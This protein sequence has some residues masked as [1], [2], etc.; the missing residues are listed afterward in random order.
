MN[1]TNFDAVE[2]TTAFLLEKTG[3]CLGLWRGRMSKADQML[4][5]GVYLGKGLIVV[6]GGDETITHW[7]K[8]CFGTDTDVTRKCKFGGPVTAR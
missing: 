1:F 6:N 5:L 7:V 8:V 3:S 2:S 4:H